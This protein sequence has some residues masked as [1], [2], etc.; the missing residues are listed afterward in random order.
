MSAFPRRAH[1]LICAGGISL[2]MVGIMVSSGL[3]PGADVPFLG[4]GLS[5]AGG[6]ATGAAAHRL[7]SGRRAPGS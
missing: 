7:M 2:F 3:L 5:V 6:V 1:W 4:S